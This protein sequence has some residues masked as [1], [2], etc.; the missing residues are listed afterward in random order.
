MKDILPKKERELKEIG[1]RKEVE[2]DKFRDMNNT[3]L[4]KNKKLLK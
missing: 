2:E 1:E 4:E 3:L